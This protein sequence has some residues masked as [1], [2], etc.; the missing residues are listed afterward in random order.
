M[1]NWQPLLTGPLALRAQRVVDEIAAVLAP[2]SSSASG[3]RLP[4]PQEIPND[5]SPVP[6]P[7]AAE[8]AILST[9][10]LAGG[11][12]GAALFFAYRAQSG[13]AG[14]GDPDTA[15]A[16]LE[17]STE[18][19]AS[20]PLAPDLYGGFAGVAWTAEH[21]YGPRFADLDGD[22]AGD[23]DAAAGEPAPE[24]AGAAGES[25]TDPD[26]LMEIDDA[27]LHYLDRTPWTADYDL[28]RGLAGLGVYAL[29]RLP[30]PSAVACLAKIVDRLSETAEHG[31]QGTTW[32]T[33]P[34]LLPDWQRELFPKGYYNLGMAHGVP[35][36][37]ALLRAA[38]AAAARLGAAGDPAAAGL[39]PRARALADG[40]IRWLLAQRLPPG[41]A[42][43]FGTTFAPESPATQSRLAWCYGDPGVA[44]ALLVAARASGDSALE[45][46]AVELALAAAER[47]LEASGVRDAGLCH[48][49]AG[50]AHLFNRFYQ[51]TG[52]R[53]LAEASLRWFEHALDFQLPGE[54]FA[55]Y[56]AYWIEPDTTEASWRN[57]AGLLEGVAGIGLALLAGIDGFE[58]AWDRILML[59]AATDATGQASRT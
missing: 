32:H 28:I 59:S 54:G 13:A 57:D 25:E 39:A 34:A 5:P 40:A 41:E 52:E 27:L 12:A 47:P 35:A 23:G 51:E 44:A 3:A 38:A 16:F 19:L 30:R 8:K 11:A 10:N 37:I 24:A 45:R 31:P 18:A 29:E 26:P 1:K 15:A 21:L 46:Q 56:R 36:V 6:D 48:G 20:T 2:G 49:S 9:P 53:R 50:L 7:L 14:A 58:P 17:R 42:S 55:G 22:A 43:C 4:E 33:A